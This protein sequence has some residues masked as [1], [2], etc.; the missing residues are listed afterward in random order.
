MRLSVTLTICNSR[1]FES[2]KSG[3]EGI[4]GLHFIG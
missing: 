2:Y 3:E 1:D 4:C